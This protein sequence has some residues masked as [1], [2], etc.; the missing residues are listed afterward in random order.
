MHAALII[1]QQFHAC[2]FLSD[3]RHGVSK[4]SK[5]VR[6]LNHVIYFIMHLDTPVLDAEE[7]DV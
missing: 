3:T 7:V 4:Q 1:L 2:E 6:H 5:T